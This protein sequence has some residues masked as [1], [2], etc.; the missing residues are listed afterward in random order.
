M[1]AFQVT[2]PGTLPCRSPVLRKHLLD[3][4]FLGIKLLDHWKGRLEGV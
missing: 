4:K 1:S 3:N 2:V